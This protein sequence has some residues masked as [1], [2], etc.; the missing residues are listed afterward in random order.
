MH[1]PW[2]S[3]L[4]AR[5]WTFNESGGTGRLSRLYALISLSQAEIQWFYPVQIRSLW[6]HLDNG[7]R[8]RFSTV[9]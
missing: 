8:F 7:Q 1:N 3:D 5:L 4:E 6:K 9:S 2:K